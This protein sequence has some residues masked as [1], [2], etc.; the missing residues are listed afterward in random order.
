MGGFVRAFRLQGWSVGARLLLINGLLAVALV[1]V[2]TIAWRALTA[3]SRAMAELA[4]ISKAARYHQDAQTL[5]ADLRADVNAA[6]AGRARSDD[7]RSELL[8]S[9]DENSKELRRD[10]LTLER[11]DL[12]ADLVDTEAKVQTL[13]D[14]YLARATELGR[15]AVRDPAAATA[16][17]PQF[18]VS[19]AALGE[20]IEKQT[21]AFSTH[22]VKAND[23]AAAAEAAAKK[24]LITAGILTN[25][26]VGLLVEWLSRSIRRSLRSVRDVAQALATGDLT[27]RN[28][29]AGPDELGELGGAINGMA[30]NLREVIGKLRAEAD[31][32]AFGTQLVEALEMADTEEEAY[33]VLGRAMTLISPDLPTELLLADSSRAHLERATQHPLAGAAGC[34]VDSPFSCMAVRRG[35][36]VT[37][38]D[39]DGLNACTRLRDRSCGP[40]AAVCVPISFMGRALGVLHSAAPA[41]KLPDERQIAQ[42]T[43]LGLQAGARIGTV[44]AFHST[45]HR[46]A[47]D[48]L[49]GLHNR[50]S[51]EERA[52]DLAAASRPFA[53]VLADLDHFKKLN[54]SRGHEAGDQALRLFADILRAQLRDQDMAARWGGEEFVLIL[55]NA[56]AKQA[57]EA[58]ERIRDGLATSLLLGGSPTFTSSFG[59]ADSSMSPRFEKLLK[60]ADEALYRAKDAGRDRVVTGSAELI[61]D[62]DTYTRHVFEHPASPN[63]KKM[64]A[65]R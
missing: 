36:A 51:A 1:F 37:F 13:A 5:Q 49:T 15:M 58:A 19:L 38:P 48:S 26:V 30:D 65:E 42:L 63:M 50:R 17:V 16:L 53:V 33:G 57:N 6:L 23:D 56:N 12:P 9:L 3:Q 41:G 32:N 2:G 43:T 34:T 24:W 25:L 22:I 18:N 62:A 7:E 31:R 4:L 46:A 28:S 64:G 10:L 35:S 8:D 20:A 54:D 59:I 11:L 39:S 60:I 14:L 47:T 44:R 29:D 45:Q 21:M 52:R 27:A 61:D 40:V 55:P